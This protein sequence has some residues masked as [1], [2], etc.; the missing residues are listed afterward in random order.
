MM[1]A[2]HTTSL[3]AVLHQEGID[4]DEHVALLKRERD[5]SLANGLSPERLTV[6]RLQIDEAKKGAETEVAGQ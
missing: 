5:V 4:L 3:T 2:N 6:T 1:S